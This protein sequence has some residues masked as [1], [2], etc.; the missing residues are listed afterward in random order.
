MTNNKGKKTTAN[1]KEQR[2]MTVYEMLIKGA[3]RPFII[4]YSSEKWGV[5]SRTVDD[6]IAI[7]T[8]RIKNTFDDKYKKN[9]ATIQVAKLNDL[10]VKNY[11]I[12]DYRECRNIIE[13]L[14]KMYGLD[15]PIKTINENIN[16]EVAPVIIQFENPNDDE[17]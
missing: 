5:V 15:A 6:Y 14:N 12:E 8:K 4:R 3:T 10:Y 11:T 17:D 13:T 16:K 2:V 9:L 7:A 1:E